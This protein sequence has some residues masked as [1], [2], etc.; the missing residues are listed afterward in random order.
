MFYWYL[1]RPT[2][3]TKKGW[4]GDVGRS[5]TTRSSYRLVGLQSLQ[6]RGE[7]SRSFSLDSSSSNASSPL[8]Q[9]AST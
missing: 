1:G 8:L 9:T 5:V 6:S 4:L 3:G 2:R 7:P